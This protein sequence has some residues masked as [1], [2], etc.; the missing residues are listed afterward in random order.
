M[1]SGS[2]HT[3]VEVNLKRED[4][5][6]HLFDDFYIPLCLFANKYVEDAELSADIVQEC[7]IKLWQIRADFTFLHQ[8]KA[9]LYT[10]VRNKCLNELEHQKVVHEVNEKIIA[11]SKEEFFHDHLIEQ[12]AYRILVGGIEQLPKQ[13][14]AIMRLALEGISNGDI[15]QELN[16]SVETVRSLKKIAYK[17][18]RTILKEYYYLLFFIF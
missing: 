8:V 15:A 4:E 14:K 6:R 9:F 18:L 16:V 3:S 11:K 1:N 7:F 10:S 13:M 12:E 2:S 17:K 5:F